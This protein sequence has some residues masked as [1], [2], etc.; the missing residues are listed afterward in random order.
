MTD[1]DLPQTIPHAQRMDS[2]PYSAIR[3]VYQAATAMQA[4]GHDIVQLTIGRPDFDTPSHIKEA[5]KAALDAGH[6]HYTSNFGLPELRAAIAA[7]L[8]D[9]NGLHF[10]PE[11]E[12][13]VVNGVSEAIATIFLSLVGPGDDVLIPVP[14]YLNYMHCATLA[15]ARAIPVPLQQ[16]DGY[17]LTAADLE[18]FVTPRSRILV[19]VSPHNPTGSVI[20]ERDMAELA[21]FA[22]RHN[23]LVVSDEIYEKLVYGSA[24]HVSIATLPGMRERTIVIN[25]FS[26]A[27]SMTGWRV[28]YIAAIKPIIDLLVRVIQYTTICPNSFAQAGAVAAL[29]GPQQPVDMMRDEFNRRRELVAGRLTELTTCSASPMEGAFYAYIDVSSITSDDSNLALR[30]LEHASVAVVPGSAFGDVGRG[31]IRISYA[32][33]YDRL[34]EGLSRLIRGLGDG[35][36]IGRS[37]L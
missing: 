9:D 34:S 32:L 7:K 18:P 25:G 37:P 30:L 12:L 27:Y 28:G 15:G 24:R 21:V 3:K 20:R 1:P 13:L 35:R 29:L 6:V 14:A 11:S 19:L 2:I 17:H 16:G 26:K 36:I 23:L 4:A 33:G 22:L 31:H 8:Q 5:A 10:D